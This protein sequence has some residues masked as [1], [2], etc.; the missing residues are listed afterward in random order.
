MDTIS[1]ERPA[2]CTE[3]ELE[4]CRIVTEFVYDE[5]GKPVAKKI[6]A[7]YLWQPPRSQHLELSIPEYR[8]FP[9]GPLLL[10]LRLPDTIL[11]RLT[12][13]SPHAAADETK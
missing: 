13:R 12:Y 3:E 4:R 10:P 7:G 8:D 11:S 5:T 1:R 2:L 9:D 6:R